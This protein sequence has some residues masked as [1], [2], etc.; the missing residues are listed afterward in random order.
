MVSNLRSLVKNAEPFLAFMCKE[1]CDLAIVTESW[2]SPKNETA[3]LLGIL[4]S[5]FNCFRC[6]RSNRR[7]GGIAVI[8][9]KFHS[10]SKIFSKSVAEA[11]E[12]LACDISLYSMDIRVIAVYRTPDCPSTKAE[13]LIKAL[14]D[15]SACHAK[16]II[17]GDFNLHHLGSVPPVSCKDVLCKKFK[18]FLSSYDFKQL[19]FFRLEIP[20]SLTSYSQMTHLLWAPCPLARQ[21]VLLTT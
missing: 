13:V 1:N 11:Y 9:N 7:G 19:H 6:D 10:S 18:S 17:A 5:N 12:I 15:L 4:S 21:L 20:H 14:S 8:V 2:L 3:P 16:C